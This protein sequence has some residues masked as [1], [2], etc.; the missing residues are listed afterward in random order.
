MGTHNKDLIKEAL[1]DRADS[2][3]REFLGEPERPSALE[4]LN[5]DAQ[6]LTGFGQRDTHAVTL[7]DERPNT[8]PKAG[9]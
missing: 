3:N 9:T 6:F 8:S 2:L 4:V 1:T 5:N 7:A